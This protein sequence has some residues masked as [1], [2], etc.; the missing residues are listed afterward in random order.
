MVLSSHLRAF[1]GNHVVG[2]RRR[3]LPALGRPNLLG[4]APVRQA[5]LV[6]VGPIRMHR[7]PQ[8]S[9]ACSTCC[10]C[11]GTAV[12]SFR[13]LVDIG[14]AEKRMQKSKDNR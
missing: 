10:C 7:K 9:R 8:H 11:C 2:A 3:F 12:G 1:H 6:L 14:Y 4:F 5:Q 13:G